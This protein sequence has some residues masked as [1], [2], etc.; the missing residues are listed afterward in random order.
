MTVQFNHIPSDMR[1]PIFAAEMD[2]SAANTATGTSKALAIG[3]SLTDTSINKP[4]S[5]SGYAQAQKSFGAGS[6]LAEMVQ[7]FRRNEA[8]MSVHCL[9]VK[10]N[11]AGTAATATIT[12]SGTAKVSGT[13][14][15]YIAGRKIQTG[16]NEG[17]AAI[18]ISVALAAA[19]NAE[20]KTYVTAE[21][22]EEGAVVTLTA[23][24]KGLSGNEI[25]LSLNKKGE[26]AGET[27][28]DGL[29]FEMTQM[30]GGTADPDISEALANLGDESYDFVIC[31]FN[32]PDAVE[33]LTD[34]FNDST[35]RWSFYKML[36]GHGFMAKRCTLAEAQ[37]YGKTLNCQH[38]TILPYDGSD[39]PSWEVA[40][41]MTGSACN[42]LASTPALPLQTLPIN[43]FEPPNIEDRFDTMERN[44]LLYCGMSTYA[45]VAGNC[46][47]DRMITTYQLNGHGEADNSYLDIETLFTSMY[48]IRFLKSRITSKYGRCSL[49]NNGTIVAE[50][51]KAVSPNDIRNELIA[52][53]RELEL[54]GLVENSAIFAKYLIV[55][56]DANDPNRVNILFPPDYVNQLRIFALLNQFRLQYKE[57][58]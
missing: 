18:E 1:V 40:A 25:K 14:N 35:G 19:I 58:N 26:A 56:L 44:T 34:F 43:G 10:E 13:I 38:L 48:V 27:T 42:S 39:T 9:P 3:L 29:S 52:A 41:E 45:V 7:G 51:V 22:A 50:G 12:V 54:Q 36:Y 49:V 16:I 28:P 5:C 37:T 30:S 20:S 47:I 17:D 4:L 33:A 6:M 2:N 32:N 24:W 8:M 21:A 57:A 46:Q 11:S 23:K 31:G 55:E 53:Y 15:L